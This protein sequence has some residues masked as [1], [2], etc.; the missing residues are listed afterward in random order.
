LLPSPMEVPVL[1]PRVS[2]PCFHPVLRDQIPHPLVA[3]RRERFLDLIKSACDEFESLHTWAT[4][5][6]ELAAHDHTVALKEVSFSLPLSSIFPETDRSS[7]SERLRGCN[8]SCPPP[9]CGHL[10]VATP[11]EASPRS[12]GCGAR[13]E[14]PVPLV[15]GALALN[16]HSD[17]NTQRAQESNGLLPTTHVTRSD[18]MIE[19]VQETAESPDSGKLSS[20]PPDIGGEGHHSH[21]RPSQLA[22]K[23]DHWTQAHMGTIYRH[24]GL[25]TG[26]ATKNIFTPYVESSYFKWSTASLIVLNS[27]MIGFE[28][29]IGM[30]R[31]QE[32]RIDLQVDLLDYFNHFFTVAFTLEL[33]LR[34]FAYRLYFFLGDEWRWNVFDTIIVLSAWA[35]FVLSGMPGASALRILRALRL[36]KTLRILRVITVFRG[37]QLL[38]QGLV[39]SLLSLLWVIFFILLAV[40]LVAI[41]FVGAA[42]S[43]IVDESAVVH[44]NTIMLSG[45][46]MTHEEMLLNF[47]KYFRTI[48][49]AMYTL[50]LCVTGGLDWYDIV[51]PL[52]VISNIY[53]VIFALYI[54]FIVFGV[55]NVLNAVFVESVI[56][57]QDKDL[58][59][60]SEQAKTR[61]FMR[62]LAELFKEGDEDGNESFSKEELIAHCRNPR[63]CAYLATHSLDASDAGVLFH[64]LDLDGSGEVGLEEF[65]LGAMKFKGAARSLD[66]Y[67]LQ[68]KVARL[69]LHVD[70][71]VRR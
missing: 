61:L 2:T 33:F 37:L 29:D 20:S 30:Q 53:A 36:S 45:D 66:L 19:T 71:L 16:G 14:Q 39:S 44:S 34:L 27:A 18:V 65:V 40:Y 48:L 3:A 32:G 68:D 54:I 55:F 35:E 5:G 22:A 58:L 62:D 49:R 56:T 24:S 57:N 60:Q 28:M 21:A 51:R 7:P 42:T 13:E 69:Q 25:L 1:P 23:T 31:A 6:I 43:Y 15:C 52:M 17:P 26:T 12:P 67:R 4:Q 70:D 41:I 63:F 10:P 11:R 8:N 46:D 47:N 9:S 38:V 50:F 59:I 64:M